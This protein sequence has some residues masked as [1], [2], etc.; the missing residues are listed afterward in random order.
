MATYKKR[1]Y[2]P[3]TKADRQAQI[4]ENSTT[5][6]VFSTL[7]A[8]ASR[9]EAWVEKN[10][11]YII[12][13]VGVIAIAAMGYLGYEQFI[14]EPKEIEATNEMFQAQTYY[15]DALTSTAKDSLYN[16]AL[17]GVGGKYG[18]LDI[19]DKY[20]GTTAANLSHYYA[21][22]S[23][24]NTGDYRNAITY[25]DKY[26]GG[27]DIT[28]PVAKGSIGDAFAQL[29]DY[30]NAL[31]YYEKAATIVTNDITTPMYLLKAGITAL[32]L[33]KADIAL[34]HF[35]KILDN[36]PSST[37]ASKATSYAAKAEAMM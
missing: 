25:L 8:G 6:E 13:V 18:F 35:N 28:G 14:Q 11:K 34:A 36:Y 1:G 29:E 20:S 16:R 33:G 12:W 31:D 26:N 22:M 9:T 19:I 24:L 37:E 3:K 2:K 10:Q 32:E 5:A 21:G 30:T 4:E 7:D 17:N 15:E 23:Y 27:D